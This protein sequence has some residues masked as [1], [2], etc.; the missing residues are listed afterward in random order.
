M[1]AFI[2]Y[3][4]KTIIDMK[5]TPDICQELEFYIYALVSPLDNSIFYIG[6]GF[7]N[8]IFE[9]EISVLN[10]PKE[11]EKNLEIRKI[12][13]QNKQV[14]KYIITYGLTEKEAF[15]VENT[16]ISF[17]Q[18][19]DKRSLKLSSLKNIISGH[20]TSKQKNKLIA[21]G[22]VAEI[23]S[24]FSPR[25]VP[26]STLN[27]GEHEEIMFV[28]IKPTP[29][30]LGKKERNLTHQKLLDPTDS[31]LRI[32]TLGDWAMNK[33]KADNI[34]YILGVYPRSGMIVSA[35]Q[36][37]V[38]KSKERYSSYDEKKNKH[39]VTRYNFNDN[40]V[41]IDKIGD[42][43]LFAKQEDG[44]IQH[45]KI[46]GTKYVDDSGKLLNIQSELVYS[47]DK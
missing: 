31:A 13:S 8:R 37:G 24:L 15:I 46:T 42:V 32:R 44:T 45:I 29:D 3:K 4:L 20:R 25:Q 11:T 27:L 38:D 30:M 21:A 33:N 17:C 40:A 43:E 34:T 18:L 9:H 41:P 1:F 12:Q 16:L 7:A 10:D 36:V 28:K 6:K 23:Q 35:Y 19:L 26:L 14:I 39:K 22:T 47:S 5:F 2:S